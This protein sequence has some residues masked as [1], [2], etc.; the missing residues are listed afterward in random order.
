MTD[1]NFNMRDMMATTTLR[2]RVRGVRSMRARLWLGAKI[3]SFA[4]WVIGCEVD[5]SLEPHEG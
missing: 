3:V 1:I 5:V 4:A 2:F